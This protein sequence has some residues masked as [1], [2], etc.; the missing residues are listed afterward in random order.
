MREQKN[1]WHFIDNKGTFELTDPEHTSYLYFP[2]MNEAGL[3]SSVTPGL[4]GD[5]KTG[6]HSWLTQPTSIEDLHNTSSIRNFWINIPGK[7]TWSATGSSAEQRAKSFMADDGDQVSLCAGF[8]WHQV[9]RLNEAVGLKSEVTNFIPTSK[10]QVE[11][12]QVRLTNLSVS[13][14]SFT[15]TAAIPIYGRSADNM[16]DHRHVTA[17]LNRIT[18]TD[19]GVQVCPTLSFDERGHFPNRIIYEVSGAEA[20]GT[21]PQGFFPILEDFI[22]EGGSLAWPEAVVQNSQNFAKA[23]DTFDGYEAL[24]GLRFA[25][26]SLLPGESC[27]Y[28]LVLGIIPDKQQPGKLIDDYGN[29][30]KFEYWLDRTKA[31]WLDRLDNLLIHTNDNRF[32]QWFKWVSIQPVFRRQFGNSFLPFHDYGKGGRGWRDLWQDILALLTMETGSVDHLLLDNFAGIRVDGS[33]ATIIGNRPGEFK[34]DR[35]NIPRVWM[36]HGAWPFLTTQLYIN[37]SGDL[38][39]LLKEQTYFKDRLIKRAQERDADWT[40]DLGTMQRTATGQVYQGT[41]LEHLLVQHLTAFFH[42]GEHNQIRLEGADWNDGLDMAEK[43]GESVAFTAMYANNLLQLGKL[44]L[45]LRDLGIDQVELG[46]ELLLLLDSFGDQVEYDSIE[47]KLQRLDD[48]FDQVSHVMSGQKVAVRLDELAA[49]L[50]GKSEWLSGQIRSREWITNQAGFGWFNGYYDNDGQR[51]EGDHPNGVRMTLTGQVFTLMGGVATQEQAREI[52][53]AVDHYLLDEHVGGHRLNT[54]FKEVLFNMGRCFGFA[55]GH[56]ENGAVF[57]HMV[58]MYAYALYERGFGREAFQV[59][60]RIYRHSVD[61]PASHMYPGIPE[62][63]DARGRGVYPF[64]TGSASWYLLTVLTQAFG[65]RGQIGDLVLCPKLVKEQFD[66]AGQANIRFWFAGRQLEVQYLNP[67]QLDFSAYALGSAELDGEKIASE[68]I[69]EGL[70]I[71]RS[72]IEQLDP[73]QLHIIRVDL[74]K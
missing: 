69:P 74:T 36:D 17:L 72:I 51:L 2:L 12:M 14:I 27:S 66:S 62:Y 54:D 25:D 16:R 35:N 21:R 73:A 60:D 48:Y 50:T 30:E 3:M 29:Q 9:I 52:V 18:C 65:V 5:I 37:Q 59:L 41:I 61:F 32:D 20:D 24:G 53:R 43:R 56:K 63:F 7:T 33:N 13:P 45:S 11:L 46:S 26:K 15:P 57:N 6:H 38:G 68:H 67:R 28:I 1:N 39:F 42:V 47:A 49:D 58:V 55:F 23:G 40:P 4:H 10:D 34:A 8:L 64:L 19:N 71:Q 44:V 22:G 31:Y 70:K